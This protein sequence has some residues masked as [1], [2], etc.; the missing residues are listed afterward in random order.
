MP[1]VT[2]AM[3]QELAASGPLAFRVRG[4][5][6]NG[7]LTDGAVASV[8]ARRAYFPG[9]VLVFRTSAE[10]IAA[11]RVLGY[12]V[13]R[14]RFAF[15]TQ[16]DGCATHDAPVHPRDVLGAAEGVRVTLADRVRASLRFLQIASRSVFR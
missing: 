8:R 1:S 9:D 16:G 11:H 3:L 15:V 5:C 7:T 14:G 6:M 13:A 2:H 4:A 12:R 10:D